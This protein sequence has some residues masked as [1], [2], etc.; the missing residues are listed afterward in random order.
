M[1]L[2]FSK[3]KQASNHLIEVFL[4]QN[5]AKLKFYQNLFVFEN[6]NEVKRHLIDKVNKEPQRILG[7]D[8]SGAQLL[9]TFMRDEMKEWMYSGKQ[10]YSFQKNMLTQG[11]VFKKSIENGYVSTYLG[12]A[13]EYLMYDFFNVR[14]P[15]V[16]KKKKIKIK[17][18]KNNVPF[19][20]LTN[21]ISKTIIS[22]IQR[23]KTFIEILFNEAKKKKTKNLKISI[24]S[25][26][27]T[28]SL[29]IL[30]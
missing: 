11:T 10:T 27:R 5:I 18:T 8:T 14:R 7:L 17:L 24:G 6:W 19:H 21:M 22:I 16:L 1:G 30:S 26:W 13:G 4:R 15:D 12:D 28:K 2:D 23:S 25:N 9:K 3:K 20:E 29:R